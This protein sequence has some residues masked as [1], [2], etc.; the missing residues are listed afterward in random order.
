MSDTT[1]MRRFHNF[2]RT[3]INIDAAEFIQAVYGLDTH[4][5][6]VSEEWAAW[7]SFRVNPYIWF[8]RASD[9]KAKRLWALIEARQPQVKP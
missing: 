7:T 4:P 9:E 2:L 8:V 6:A 1:E 5:S 3:M